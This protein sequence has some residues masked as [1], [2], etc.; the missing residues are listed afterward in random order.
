VRLAAWQRCI[1]NQNVNT[2]FQSN[3][4]ICST[5]FREEDM[6][7]KPFTS[8]QWKDN[9]YQMEAQQFVYL[10]PEAVPVYF[11]DPSKRKPLKRKP[12]KERLPLPPKKAQ[13]DAVPE[14]L[15]DFATT[16]I[17]TPTSSPIMFDIGSPID[18]SPTEDDDLLDPEPSCS[19]EPVTSDKD[20]Y[21]IHIGK[22]ESILNP[23][24]N[25]TSDATKSQELSSSVEISQSP[26]D[27]REAVVKYC[28][29]SGTSV[30]IPPSKV[31]ERTLV[32]GTNEI[33]KIPEAI[34]NK[35][36]FVKDKT[37]EGNEKMEF[38]SPSNP[39]AASYVTKSSDIMK[40]RSFYYTPPSKKLLI[41]HPPANANSSWTL[42][43]IDKNEPQNNSQNNTNL[44][45]IFV[46]ENEKSNESTV[47]R[48]NISSATKNAID[49]MQ[50]SS[51]CN[52]SNSTATVV[53]PVKS[54]ATV[55]TP[56]VSITVP[57]LPAAKFVHLTPSYVPPTEICGDPNAPAGISRVFTEPALT[58]EEFLSKCDTLKLPSSQWAM[59]KHINGKF[60]SFN[61]IEVHPSGSLS[62][63]RIVFHGNLTPKIWLDGVYK[64][65]HLFGTLKKFCDL[66]RMIDMYNNMESCP[67]TEH[68]AQPFS[69]QCNIYRTRRMKRCEPC[70][71]RKR[72]LEKR[73][74]N[75]KKRKADKEKNLETQKA[76]DA[77]TNS[78]DA[79]ASVEVISQLSRVE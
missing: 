50:E 10:K 15:Y 67:G 62:E 18:I 27:A 16:D 7:E 69:T 60:V 78:A 23:R 25:S 77:E 11:L 47:V 64:D 34:T 72:V 79:A 8:L 29:S 4:F 30:Q 66:L 43:I 55:L 56:P 21:N 39:L 59:Q 70:Q 76:G 14:E 45:P 13:K 5:H 32:L 44:I 20:S 6:F 37:I 74:A 33:Q 73:D 24:P 57:N 54:N 68:S 63:K 46:N 36:I 38:N 17:V 41:R 9:Q 35:I 58:Y 51:L 52:A 1:K 22:M 71:H 12:P 49:V 53:D 2:T 75:R 26:Q 65:T 40:E 48:V 61:Y 31:T 42:Q 19:D 28:N 3:D